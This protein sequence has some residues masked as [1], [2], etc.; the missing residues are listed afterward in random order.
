MNFRRGAGIEII[1]MHAHVENA[2]RNRLLPD[3][4]KNFAQPPGQVVTAHGNADKHDGR[5]AFIPFGDFV[6]DAG[7]RALDC[8]GVEDDGGFS[9]KPASQCRR[10]KRSS[11]FRCRA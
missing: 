9:H 10:V 7:E 6:R 11:R 4:G 3:I 1:A 5:S 8:G 2:D